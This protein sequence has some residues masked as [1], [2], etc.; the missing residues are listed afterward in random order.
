[1][2]IGTFGSFTQSRLAIYAAQAAITVA[3]NN[4]ANINTPGYT[5]QKLDQSSLYIGGTDR[6][7]SK[8][9]LRIGAGV[10][11]DGVS[12]IR[13]KYLD[14]RYRNEMASVGAQDEWLGGLEGIAQILD[15]VGDGKITAGEDFGIIS[16]HLKELYNAING[17]TDQTGHTE[18]DYQV[19]S[20]AD[21][22]AKAISSYASRL[23]G[24]Y[25]DTMINFKEDLQTVNG[26]LTDIRNLNETIR[27]SDI[28]GDKALE[29]RDQR[30]MKLDQLSEYMKIN[31]I[32]TT[33]NLGAGQTIEKLVLKL[34][35]ANPDAMVDSDETVLIDGIYGSQISVV[36]EPVMNPKHDV[37][38]EAFLFQDIYGRDVYT[39]NTEDLYGDKVFG[40]VKDTTDLTDT[41]F[42][43]LLA[44]SGLTPPAGKQYAV[45]NPRGTAIIGFT[46]D[47]AAVNPDA[48]PA[49]APKYLKPDGTETDNIQDAA[50]VDN[51][52]LNLTV[53]E[54]RD[55]K[56]R[57]LVYN[58]KQPEET[59][60]KKEYDDIL[61]ANKQPSTTETAEDGISTKI[62]TYWR[63]IRMLQIREAVKLGPDNKPI[64]D[65]DG[66]PEHDYYYINL[67]GKQV[68]IAEP[69]GDPPTSSYVDE[70]GTTINIS[71]ENYAAGRAPAYSYY[72]QAFIQTP[73]QRVDLDDNDLKGRIQSYR[74]L[75]TEAGEF[76]PKSVINGLDENGDPLSA[77]QLLSCDENAGTKRG[78]PY[79]QKTLD[80]LAN[81][82]A[83]AFNNANQ[84]YLTDP[85]GNLITMTWDPT[86]NF[87]EGALA[88][89][90]TKIEYQGQ[91]LDDDGNPVFEADGTTPVMEDKE[92]TFNTSYMIDNGTWNMDPAEGGLPQEVQ[93]AIKA[94]LDKEGVA[95]GDPLT[96]DDVKAY[97]NLEKTVY[98]LDKDGNQVLDKDGK[99]IPIVDA[100]GKEVKTTN[101]F[102]KGAPMFSNHGSSNDTEGITARN[103]SISAI[104]QAE[105][106]LIGSFICPPGDYE[107]ASTDSNNLLENM[108]SLFYEK[109]D[110]YPD[111]LEDDAAHEVMFN[112]TFREFWI[113]IGTTMGEDQSVTGSDLDNHYETSIEIDT[114]RDSVFA[115]DFNDEAMNLFMYS[116]A[117]NAACRVLTTLDSVLDKLINGTGVTT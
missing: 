49:N 48:D 62:T 26:L 65:G 20:A 23:E 36:Q 76:T 32:Y 78:I 42:Q 22:L 71:A 24:Y 44:D 28:Y 15:E 63:N 70:E 83:Y 13:D 29:L 55:S 82:L 31:V 4:V 17:L 97:M 80:L 56:G 105:P 73:S 72:K 8:S 43:K 100:A 2:A 104:W 59:I 40:E 18:Y 1:M 51:A 47:P 10:L 12:Q 109:Q 88:G 108:T 106:V 33:E 41:A 46:D 90:P 111:T 30:N 25:N 79:Y 45:L 11:C 9:N 95:H 19:R 16:A 92:F 5:R 61:A 107:P 102:F 74:E 35:D 114:S 67:N 60:T 89:V 58:S 85:S 3:G 57:V 38:K 91:K 94:E 64:L 84:G 52:N 115:V 112:G 39:D 116:Q 34:G 110:Y 50:T 113:S 75:L 103:I 77:D 93:D 6:Y 96:S 14:I 21:K 53:S 101:A 117:Y 37:T 66:N 87:N 27:T 69:T 98:Q 99:P 86:A 54:L 7:Y 68:R 81:R